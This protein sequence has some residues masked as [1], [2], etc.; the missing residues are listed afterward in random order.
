M[1]IGVLCSHHFPPLSVLHIYFVHM[2]MAAVLHPA[3]EPGDFRICAW[4]HMKFID[5]TNTRIVLTSS[6]MSFFFFFF[7]AIVIM[8]TYIIHFGVMFSVH[9]AKTTCSHVLLF[10]GSHKLMISVHLGF[11]LALRSPAC[12]SLMFGWFWRVGSKMVSMDPTWAQ[13]TRS[14]KYLWS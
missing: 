1:Y 5:K 6:C 8:T 14:Y 3:V 10:V 11:F 2:G 9:L 13:T 4:Q 12:W 7:L